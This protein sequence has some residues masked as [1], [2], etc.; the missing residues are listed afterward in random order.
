MT[1]E[2]KKQI[3]QK[4]SQF[5]KLREKYGDIV[6]VDYQGSGDSFDSFYNCSADYEFL[7]EPGINDLLW[8]A[9]EKSQANFN[10]EGSEGKITFYLKDKKVNIKNYWIT[11]ET[12]LSDDID[13]DL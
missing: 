7:N 10:N 4:Y 13:I 6:E 9:I 3:K 1:K 11:Y 5:E 8:E 2:E 12:E